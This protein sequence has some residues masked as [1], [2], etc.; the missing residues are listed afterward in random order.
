[1]TSLWIEHLLP[2][3]VGCHISRQPESQSEMQYK[4]CSWDHKRIKTHKLSTTVLETGVILIRKKAR[5]LTMVRGKGR[6]GH[7][8]TSLCLG[9][10]RG[11]SLQ[12]QVDSSWQICGTAV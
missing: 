4:L 6:W 12:S 9:H 5:P 7:Y 1:M 3:M 2:A 10:F 11:D 8:H